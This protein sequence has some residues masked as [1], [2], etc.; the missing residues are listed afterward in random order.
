MVPNPL[1]LVQAHPLSIAL[2][3]A[4]GVAWMAAEYYGRRSTWKAGAVRR[5]PSTLDRG[6]YPAIA[7]SIAVG[8]VS[9]VVAF[10]LE[11]GGLLPDW[12]SPLGLMVVA[13]GLGIRVWALRT[14]GRFFTMPITLRDDHEIV[15]AGP[16][17]WLR[18][19]AYTG[20]FVT[21]I[22]MTLCL[23]PWVGL[24]VTFVACLAAYVY[25]IRIEEATLVSRFGEEYRRYAAS[26]WRLLPLLY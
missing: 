22:G 3:A 21:A 2:T 17:R 5:P 16:Y 14:L 15:R 11:I 4:G 24:V 13:L 26:T 12:V 18:H 10:L 6:T 23:G 20:G 9:T 7:V 1:L 8:M 25:R 19:P